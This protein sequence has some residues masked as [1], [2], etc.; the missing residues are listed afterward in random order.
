MALKSREGLLPPPN[1]YAQIL[2]NLRI[3]YP[4]AQITAET[5]ANLKLAW[6]SLWR[7]GRPAD[8]VAKTTCS[9][10]GKHITLSPA[11]GVDVPKRAYRGPK[12]AERGALFEPSEMRESAPVE[13]TV[14]SLQRLQS[15]ITRARERR[16]RFQT[17]A[18]RA[19]KPEIQGALRTQISE[20]IAAIDERQKQADEVATRLQKLRAQLGSMAIAVSPPAQP[21]RKQRDAKPQATAKSP[22]A[23]KAPPK[24]PKPP[25]TP[26]PPKAP[27]PPKIG[28]P[29]APASPTPSPAPKAP[30]PPAPPAPPALSASGGLD[31]GKEALILGEIKSMLPGLAQQMVQELQKSKGGG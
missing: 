21:T 17:R 27:K 19:T 23:P 5:M 12:G 24:A 31:P 22:S 25:K 30:A 16:D 13:R 20:Q 29:K 10:D 4:D 15:D 7:D 28:E 1:F 8:V 9:C 18:D 14:R 6:D 11:F 26:K 3:A 2:A